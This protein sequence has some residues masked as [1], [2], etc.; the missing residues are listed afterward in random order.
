MRI[1]EDHLKGENR[2]RSTNSCSYCRSKD[3]DVRKCPE[4]PKDWEEGWKHNTVPLKTTNLKGWKLTPKYW[5]EWYLKCKEVVEKQ[6]K[7]KLKEKQPKPKRRLQ[8]VH[9]GFCGERGHTRKHCPEMKTF[10]ERAH[11][12]NQK[13]MKEAWNYLHNAQQIRVGSLIK[14]LVP[15]GASYYNKEYVEQIA[16]IVSINYSDLTLACSKE[17]WSR[18]SGEDMRSAL[19]IKILVGGEVKTLRSADAEYYGEVKG[20]KLLDDNI[21][22]RQCLESKYN[23][24]IFNG[25]LSNVGVVAYGEALIKEFLTK[26][27]AAFD[28]VARKRSEEK[29][30]RAGLIKAIDRWLDY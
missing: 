22:S 23:S 24:P 2:Y 19:S 10:I 3:H 12:A 21:F 8:D 20:K 29:L 18:Y 5:G 16:T 9:C 26:S 17:Y 28:F 13:W 25:V 30:E 6:E 14:V 4:A 11:I 1:Y 7:L 27:N 15:Q